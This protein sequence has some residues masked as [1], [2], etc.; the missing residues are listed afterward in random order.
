MLKL[1][2]VF[3]LITFSI[4]VF[5]DIFLAKQALE[6]GNFQHAER[7]LQSVAEVGNDEAQYALGLLYYQGKLGKVDKINGFAWMFVAT[8]YEHPIAAE[9][10]NQIFHELKTPEQLE[11]KNLAVELVSKYGPESLYESV[12]PHLMDKKIPDQTITQSAIETSR[13]EIFSDNLALIDTKARA[14]NARVEQIQ[15]LISRLNQGYRHNAFDNLEKLRMEDESG[16]VIIK[17]DVN[18]F[19]D[20]IDPQVIFSWPH[21]RFDEI[22]LEYTKKRKFTPA[23]QGGEVIEQFGLI[24]IRRVGQTAPNSYRTAYPQEHRAFLSI[25]KLA[26]EQGDLSAKYQ[27]ANLLRAYG[28]I[29]AAEQ[30][31][32]YQELLKELAGK[33]F[34]LAQFD[35]AQYLI[36][37]ERNLDIGLGW[38]VKAVKAGHNE[39]E[40]RMADILSKPPS[41]YLVR[42]H[43]KAKFWYERAKTK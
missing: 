41:E 21:S 29:I 31:V 28:D 10:A 8:A 7:H 18:K 34:V 36:Y 26:L 9:F 1:I 6:Q 2:P 13:E 22:M 43:Q 12:Y 33:G 37:Q 17:H 24:D 35:Y 32:T 23:K 16:L 4:N 25:K 42:D 19:G 20:V 5:A 38:L 3:F 40:K 27:L 14:N 39:A 11:A 30:P 15:E